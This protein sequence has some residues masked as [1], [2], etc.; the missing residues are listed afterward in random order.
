[1]V[2]MQPILADIVQ[3]VSPIVLVVVAALSIIL[4]I[5]VIIYPALL[6]WLVGI[7]LVLVGVALLASVF[8]AAS[9]TGPYR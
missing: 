2:T 8:T 4:G 1:M 9:Q 7:G 3:G 6:P 5:L